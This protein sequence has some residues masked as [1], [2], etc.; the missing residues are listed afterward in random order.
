MRR[1][2]VAAIVAVLALTMALPATAF[3]AIHEIIG[4]ECRAGGEEVRPPG[5][6]NF[7]SQSALRALQASGVIT[8][9]TNVGGDVTITFD[10]SR[11]NVKYI[12]AGFDLT[13]PDAFGPGNDLTLS[14]LPIPDPSFPAYANCRNLNP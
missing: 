5:Q 8:S 14:P 2:H 12:S 10:L 1:V 4:A 3:G 11:P 9:I 7:G 6:I 13:I